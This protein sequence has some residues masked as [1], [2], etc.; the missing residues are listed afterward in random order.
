MEYLVEITMM[1]EAEDEKKAK[2]KIKE[3]LKN[4]EILDKNINVKWDI[5]E[6]L[7]LKAYV[8]ISSYREKVMTTLISSYGLTP[9]EIANK[10]QINRNHISKV[11]KEL[12]NKELIECINPEM[13]KGKI[14]KLTSLGRKVGRLL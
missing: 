11:L 5:Y 9:T 4:D 7:K 3:L 2:E 12:T 6:Y 14:Y 8:C 13:R 1:V 10:S